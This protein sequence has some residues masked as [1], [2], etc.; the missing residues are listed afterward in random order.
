[1]KA[2]ALGCVLS[3]GIA[4]LACLTPAE[5][6]V[7]VVATTK[8]IHALIARVMAGI[9]SPSLLIKGPQ[10]PHTY[11]LKPSDVRTLNEADLFFRMSETVEPFTVK[12]V[13]AL[14]KTL[15]VVALQDAPGVRLLP[16][17]SQVGDPDVD[18]FA[19]ES[20]DP[21]AVDGHTWLDPDN[22]RAMVERIE[23]ALGAYDPAGAPTYRSNARALKA[24]LVALAAELEE[25]LRPVAQKG[26]IVYH[27]ALQ[28]FERR[29]GLTPA[30]AI[31]IRAEVPPSAKHLTAL[32]GKIRAGHVACV[33]TEPQDGG[34]VV[35]A[36][37]EGSDAQVAMLDPEALLLE[38]GPELYFTL[39]RK[40]ATELTRC[41]ASEDAT[42]SL[43]RRR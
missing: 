3:A 42:T 41:L 6:G 11:A 40:L 43:A 19:Y 5:A 18:G 31:S 1:V 28:Y 20:P 29:F 36:V 32:R 14:P 7:R 25:R 34:R 26:Y 39:M 9:G 21:R 13:H 4:T 8:P 24:D 33:F 38:P 37:I 35:R 23:S 22:A 12:V 17:R 10:S 30:G 2:R 27:D 16:V 15:R